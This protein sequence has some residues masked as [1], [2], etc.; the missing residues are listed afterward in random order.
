MKFRT[1]MLR[2]MNSVR[3]VAIVTREAAENDPGTSF[4]RPVNRTK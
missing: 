2:N 4:S 1:A 3:I